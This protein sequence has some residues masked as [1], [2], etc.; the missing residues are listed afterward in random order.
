M[1]DETVLLSH[2]Q[3]GSLFE[4]DRKIYKVQYYNLDMI[5]LVDYYAKSKNGILFFICNV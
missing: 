1:K 4:K 2:Q 3:M 5:I